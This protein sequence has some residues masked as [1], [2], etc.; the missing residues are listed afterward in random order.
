M[1]IFGAPK[2]V[3]AI[4]RMKGLFDNNRKTFP[5]SVEELGKNNLGDYI[6]FDALNSVRSLRILKA[7]QL[8]STSSFVG[9]MKY[10][11]VS[12]ANEFWVTLFLAVF[13]EESKT[14]EEI[15]EFNQ[16]LV[17]RYHR[18]LLNEETGDKTLLMVVADDLALESAKDDNYTQYIVPI[19][20][21]VLKGE[22][23]YRFSQ[24]ASFFGDAQTASSFTP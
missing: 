3:G 11:P 1:S 23:M 17:N 7:W 9:A 16:P 14:D 12:S 13:D 15:M 24:T 19:L 21:A 18:A 8:V 4:G 6:N 22:M 2:W 5:K 20:R 10:V